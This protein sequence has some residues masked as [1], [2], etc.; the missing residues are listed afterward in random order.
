MV[1]SILSK[2]YCFKAIYGESADVDSLEAWR[3][4]LQIILRDYT[5]VGTKSFIM[6]CPTIR[7][8]WKVTKVPETKIDNF[9]LYECGGWKGIHANHWEKK[10]PSMR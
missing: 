6:K 3:K 10:K 5:V 9:I 8:P 1:G 7:L 4:S 2:T